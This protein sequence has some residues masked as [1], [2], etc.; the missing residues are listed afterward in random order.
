VP[1]MGKVELVQQILPYYQKS[2]LLGIQ[3]KDVKY[4]V[5]SILHELCE[6]SPTWA[7]RFIG[8]KNKN[9]IKDWWGRL[10]PPL[11]VNRHPNGFSVNFEELIVLASKQKSF[12]P[13]ISSFQTEEE[14]EAQAEEIAIEKMKVK[15]RCTKLE[16]KVEGQRKR[17]AALENAW[18]EFQELVL[19][20]VNPWP[21]AKYPLPNKNHKSSDHAAIM[22][23]S[24]VHVGEFVKSSDIMGL[25]SF[26]WSM[27]LKRKEGYMAG[28]TRIFDDL[29][30]NHNFKLGVIN[31]L[32]EYATGENTF[33]LQMARLDKHIHE[34]IVDSAMHMAD[35]IRYICTLTPETRFY[36]VPGNHVVSRDSTMILDLMIYELIRH[37]LSNQPNFKM[38]V[39]E[40]PYIGY[41]L[42]D[43]T[44]PIEYHKPFSWKFLITHGHM[45]KRHYSL[46]YYAIDRLTAKMSSTVGHLFDHTF[47][48]H[49][50]EHAGTLKWSVNGSWLGGTGYSIEKMQSVEPPTQ[51]FHVFHP[52]YGVCYTAPIYL[53]E[54]QISSPIDEFGTIGE[55]VK[56]RV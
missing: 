39:S 1:N 7:A 56:E 55:A 18:E 29:S 41:E 32:G 25:G 35:I 49:S 27:F 46:P 21:A 20:K 34:Q 6:G 37:K 11:E 23:I 10:K 19:S 13:V 42:S 24:D 3:P 44:T 33:P 40:C 31:G 9:K 2:G 43:K 22:N 5:Y 53:D 28:L 4:K 30:P 47:L 54:P 12:T 14:Q 36:G 16:Q 50:H 52:R 45:C 51:Q 48:A 15:L 17:I 8:I 26:S 38:I